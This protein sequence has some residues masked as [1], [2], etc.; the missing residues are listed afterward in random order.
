MLHPIFKWLTVI[1]LIMTILLGL[2]LRA[3]KLDL[4]W[5]HGT[6]MDATGG[7]A[8]V[9]LNERV[10][11]KRF[12]KRKYA[13]DFKIDD[14]TSV[15]LAQYWGHRPLAVGKNDLVTFAVS[16]DQLFLRDAHG[17]RHRLDVLSRTAK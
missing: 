17:T 8:Q 2:P 5:Q 3:S 6:V 13:W 1:P 15:I 9:A 10:K 16:G 14:G 4:A 7:S 12:S 11:N